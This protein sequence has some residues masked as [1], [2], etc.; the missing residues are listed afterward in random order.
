[1]TIIPQNFSTDINVIIMYFGKYNATPKA[2]KIF[3]ER[4]HLYFLH[5]IDIS[6]LVQLK[7]KH[8]GNGP[9]LLTQ[10]SNKYIHGW[11]L[12]FNYFGIQESFNERNF[13]CKSIIFSPPYSAE[14]M[15][16]VR[17]ILFSFRT[18]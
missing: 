10:K 14:L 11:S 3:I 8:N 13:D 6:F 15:H 12:Y 2:Q 4:W 16:T 9:M 17:F 7:R 5:K 18:P 1:M